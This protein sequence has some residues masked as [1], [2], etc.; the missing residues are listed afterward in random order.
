MLQRLQKETGECV[1]VCF[2]CVRACCA[3]VYYFKKQLNVHIIHTEQWL[4]VAWH[5]EDGHSIVPIKH[6]VSAPPH[7]NGSEVT[8]KCGK[9]Q[10]KGVV[11][12][13]GKYTQQRDDCKN[14][15]SWAYRV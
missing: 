5:Q 7:T 1:C 15:I 3:R 4:L 10:Y 12:T 6:V 8:V 11:L 9:S 14:S 13:I 2:V